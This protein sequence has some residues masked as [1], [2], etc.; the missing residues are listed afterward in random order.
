LNQKICVI[1]GARGGIGSAVARLFRAEGAVVIAADIR[2]T[3][4]VDKPDRNQGAGELIWLEHDVSVEDSWIR[5]IDAVMDRF[6]RIDVLVNNAGIASAGDIEETT[7]EDWRRVMA[8]NLDGI[9][10]GVKHTIKAM[11]SGGGGSIVNIASVAGI[12]GAPFLPAYSAS[13][14][15]VTIFTKSAALYCAAKNY[16][17][18]VNS[19][20]PT[21]TDTPMIDSIA[22]GADDVSRLKR[23]LALL[24]PMGRLAQPDDVANAVLFLASDEASFLTGAAITVD[25]GYTAQ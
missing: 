4:T 8:V 9:F 10:L 1:T 5:L 14:G 24:Q 7:L 19:V 23:R 11:K 2:S 22:G 6:E 16:S 21:F 12:V 3:D 25:G 20:H 17:I 18:R 15:G 13:K